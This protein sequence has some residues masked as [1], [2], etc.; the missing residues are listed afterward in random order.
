MSFSQGMGDVRSRLR[1]GIVGAWALLSH[2]NRYDSGLNSDPQGVAVKTLT[3]DTATNDHEYLVTV[4][5]QVISYTADGATSKTEVRDGLTAAINANAIARGSV[6]ADADT[7]D[8]VTLTGLYPG[9][10]FSVVDVD[11]L[12]TLATDTAAAT[13]DPIPF[14]RAVISDGLVSNES[15]RLVKI[16]KSTSF[17]AQVQTVEVAYIASAVINVRVYEVRGDDRVLLAEAEHASATDQ[18]TTL[19]TLIADLNA[20]LPANTV[21]VA[22]DD[23]PATALVFTAEIAGLEFVSEVNDI[24]GGATAAAITSTNTTGPSPSTSLHRALKGISMYSHDPAATIGGSEGEYAAN[25]GV[26][27]AETGPLWVDDPGSVVAGTT[28]YIELDGSGTEAGRPYNTSS[29]TRV[30]LS[31]QVAR[32]E[33]PGHTAADGLAVLRLDL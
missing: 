2:L 3:V 30:A 21:L 18:D 7:A 19:D 24:G 13:A 25:A 12:L 17:T 33:R 10:D 8:V 9:A 29:S 5:G 31:R 15:T 11:A 1:Q 14:G 28:V 32:W 4:Q 26:R 16:A 20:R 22:A 27:Y 6:V 23:D